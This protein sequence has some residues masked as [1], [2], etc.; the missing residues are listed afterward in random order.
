VKT[1]SLKL[2]TKK[3]TTKASTKLISLGPEMSTAA[4]DTMLVNW[5]NS[6][7]NRVYS[8]NEY[9]THRTQLAELVHDSVEIEN[10]PLSILRA[11]IN[12]DAFQLRNDHCLLSD[13]T[14]QQRLCSI[15][16]NYD[17]NCLKL[18][19]ETVTGLVIPFHVTS[20]QTLKSH[21]MT[22]LLGISS[23]NQQALL[24][25]S[26]VNADKARVLK[27]ELQ[28]G[29][30][31]RL[32]K[33]VYV[34]DCAKGTIR[35]FPLLFNSKAQ[36]KTSAEIFIEINKYFL[37]CEENIIKH[38]D[39]LHVAVHVVQTKV[40]DYCEDISIADLSSA[41][42][43][44]GTV[45]GRLVEILADNEKYSN[46]GGTT[47][48]K[49]LASDT[50]RFPANDVSLRRRNVKFCLAML[51]KMIHVSSVN[52][53]PHTNSNGKCGGKHR[54]RALSCTRTATKKGLATSITHQLTG[55]ALVTAVVAGDKVQTTWLL[56]VMMYM[57]DT[58]INIVSPSTVLCEVNRLCQLTG[59]VYDE[60]M[61]VSVKDSLFY[62]CKSVA[63]VH[64]FTDICHTVD[65]LIADTDT[66]K[67]LCILVHNYFPKLLTIDDISCSEGCADRLHSSCKLIFGSS[68][69]IPLPINTSNTESLLAESRLIVF[70]GR[71]FNRVMQ[72]RSQAHATKIIT[73]FVLKFMPA[74]RAKIL[75]RRT[76]TKHL[77]RRKV[78]SRLEPKAVSATLFLTKT[79]AA[80]IIQR[81]FQLF[82]NF[83]R[84]SKGADTTEPDPA[85]SNIVVPPTEHCAGNIAASEVELQSTLV[86]DT[87][88]S[89][90][91]APHVMPNSKG[92]YSVAS[93]LDVDFL[94]DEYFDD[95]IIASDTV[96]APSPRSKPGEANINLPFITMAGA[97][98]PQMDPV[99]CGLRMSVFALLDDAEE[100][101]DSI[102][103][104][105]SD[106]QVKS[107]EPTMIVEPVPVSPLPCKLQHAEEVSPNTRA[108]MALEQTIEDLRAEAN[109]TNMQAELRME[110][111]KNELMAALEVERQ[112][113][114]RA[115]QGLYE[116]ERARKEAELRLFSMEEQRRLS[117]LD[118]LAQKLE[119]E[120]QTAERFRLNRA[121]TC[122]QSSFR[123]HNS[124]A[125]YKR[126]LALVVKL[127]ASVRMF[128][129]HR[130]YLVQRLSVS[131]IQSVWRR[132][133]CV[134]VLREQR[135]LASQT[136]QR[137]RIQVIGA[138]TKICIFLKLRM[139]KT[140]QRK[141]VKILRRSY[142]TYRCRRN[143]RKFKTGICK[144]QV[145][146]LIRIVFL[147]YINA[148]TSNFLLG[149]L[150]K[151]FSHPRSSP[152]Q[153]RFV[154]PARHYQTTTASGYPTGTR[155]SP[156]TAGL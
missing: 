64:G 129:S 88:D 61:Q 59:V 91:C 81:F 52:T 33:L 153:R 101:P 124:R 98:E 23:A 82:G 14:L 136:R 28:H 84:N 35:N 127:Q 41:D 15:L 2:I 56:H 99:E 108:R 38:L 133:V 72:L 22:H 63:T 66:G 24:H 134:S 49:V 86:T 109:N 6:K 125:H 76:K 117:E 60:Q 116:T 131:L 20:R 18:G 39:S 11:H 27:Q 36:I 138:F 142:L 85:C 93:E 154:F 111:L 65:D 92:K 119:W 104:E 51:E 106:D 62:W 40:E 10:S 144:L 151:M 44:N 128:F 102:F 5:V 4:D 132:H 78:V 96:T 53:T 156:V 105:G 34:L 77:H 31:Y 79:Q 118:I 73:A 89:E 90:L 50:F 126:T 137:F 16:F 87:S 19:L 97:E 75:A 121:S 30:L 43:R 57:L 94:L 12:R 25:W 68:Q 83:R 114:Q 45:V 122:I 26:V 3:P 8:D 9:R 123:T 146:R 103:S 55:D 143:A 67:L 37:A 46:D 135:R 150:E 145:G 95:D 29:L 140:S 100:V 54:V 110:A 48:F 80:Y 7:L 58:S 148:G 130:R 42:L 70:L 13:V 149:C 74:F 112:N 141:A 17:I 113:R 120:R 147:Q 115:E 139:R 1:G 71:L 21:I 47:N 155:V 69:Q 152:L 32:F 107:P